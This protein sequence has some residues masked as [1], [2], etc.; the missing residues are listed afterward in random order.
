VAR[1]PKAPK[2]GNP[3]AVAHSKRG[4]AGS[5]AHSNKTQRESEVPRKRKHKGRKPATMEDS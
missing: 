4:P 3:I 2:P 5:G 1:N